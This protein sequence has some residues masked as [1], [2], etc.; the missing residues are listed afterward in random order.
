[1]LYSL[2]LVRWW[3]ADFEQVPDTVLY[4]WCGYNEIPTLLAIESPVAECNFFWTL[5]YQN[6]P[7]SNLKYKN[8]TK[9]WVSYSLVSIYDLFDF[10][11]RVTELQSM[12]ALKITWKRLSKKW[13]LKRVLK[14]LNTRLHEHNI[15]QAKR[16]F[17]SP[18]GHVMFY[19]SLFQKLINY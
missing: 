10:F 11:S 9:Y 8:S 14:E 4:D 17:I 15:F 12:L 3:T 18:S 16:N 6:S 19:L 13:L 2:G 1:M 7:S 5:R